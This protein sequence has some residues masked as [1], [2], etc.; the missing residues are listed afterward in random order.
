MSS[1]LFA[2][3][4][5]AACSTTMTRPAHPTHPTHDEAL[6]RIHGMTAATVVTELDDAWGPAT[7]DVGSGIHIYVYPMAGG[8][9]LRVGSA[10]GKTVMYVVVKDAT[11]ERRFDVPR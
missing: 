3:I 4:L 1:R 5:L 6:A 7:A 11:G 2:L 9:T 10:D 8:G